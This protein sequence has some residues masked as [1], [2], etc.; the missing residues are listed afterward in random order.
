MSVDMERQQNC[1]VPETC[2]M[3]HLKEVEIKGLEMIE[4]LQF[5]KFI[6]QNT[7]ALKKLTANSV[8]FF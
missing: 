4:G 2:S 7:K 3:L 8:V 1:I 5:L 6:V